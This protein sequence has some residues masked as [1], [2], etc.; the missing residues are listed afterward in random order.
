MVRVL[1]IFCV[2]RMASGHSAGLDAF[3]LRILASMLKKQ[4]LWGEDDLRKLK[5]LK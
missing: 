2:V 5:L 4:A 3:G 1:S